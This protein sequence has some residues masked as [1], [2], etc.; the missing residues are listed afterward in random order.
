VKPGQVFIDITHHATFCSLILL[1][2]LSRRY[3]DAC[4]LCPNVATDE[5]DG[6]MNEGTQIFSNLALTCPHAG[7]VVPACSL[8]DSPTG[9][10]ED[11]ETRRLAVL[12]HIPSVPF[13]AL[14][15]LARGE[16]RLQLDLTALSAAGTEMNCNYNGDEG[17]TDEVVDDL[18]DEVAQE[19]MECKLTVGEEQYDLIETCTYDGVDGEEGALMNCVICVD[20][21]YDFEFC[22]EISCDFSALFTNPDEFDDASLPNF[23]QNACKCNFATIDGQ[24]W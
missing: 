1:L 18:P 3:S 5:G 13:A 10:G 17:I 9:D 20:D 21:Q 19:A 8:S 24:D 7:L 6:G 2:C 4:E 16:R 22:Y 11:G 23:E 12:G 15:K 14:H